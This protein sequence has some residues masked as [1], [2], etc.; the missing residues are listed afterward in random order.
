MRHQ[1]ENLPKRTRRAG[2][3]VHA[4]SRRPSYI[5]D[6]IPDRIPQIRRDIFPST[7][8]PFRD[9]FGE[10]SQSCRDESVEHATSRWREPSDGM[11]TLGVSRLLDQLAVA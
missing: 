5:G 9:K 8:L 4:D 10:M 11:T 3:G 1:L 7:R 6:Q 2:G